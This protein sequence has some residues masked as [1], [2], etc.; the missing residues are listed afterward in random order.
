M[1]FCI[2]SSGRPYLWWRWKFYSQLGRDTAPFITPSWLSASL[3]SSIINSFLLNTSPLHLVKQ[4]FQRDIRKVQLPSSLNSRTPR[5]HFVHLIIPTSPTSQHPAGALI[6]PSHLPPRISISS[7]LTIT[8]KFASILHL[9]PPTPPSLLSSLS[10]FS[11]SKS[12]SKSRI[13][14]Y[15]PIYLPKHPSPK[16]NTNLYQPILTSPIT[17]HHSLLHP[18]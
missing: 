3:H 16:S 2:S 17:P 10:T 11:K 1:Q 9:Y 13:L 4:P 14:T 6:P 12:K 18:S 15:L 5:F 8:Y 7:K